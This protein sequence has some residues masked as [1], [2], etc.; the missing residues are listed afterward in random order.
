MPNWCMNSVR[1]TGPADKI[2]EVR[3]LAQ[4]YQAG[5]TQHFFQTLVPAIEPVP[6]DLSNSDWWD[7]R[8]SLWGTKWE[9]SGLYVGAGSDGD[10]IQLE[11]DT[12]WGPPMG[13]L[14]HLSKEFEVSAGYYEPGMY[15]AGYF[16]G[17]PG[18]EPVDEF[19]QMDELKD[20]ELRDAFEAFFSIDDIVSAFSYE[21]E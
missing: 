19:V 14:N 5:E 1:I 13:I 12:A 17:K 10:M 6:D 21:E 3:E 9:P 8:I 4:A 20:W 2:A 7:S 18:A 16:R 15:F 11:F